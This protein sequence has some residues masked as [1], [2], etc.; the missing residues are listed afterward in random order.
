MSEKGVCKSFAFE[1]VSFFDFGLEIL[2]RLSSIEMN[3]KS[4]QME[5][6]DSRDTEIE[7]FPPLRIRKESNIVI[8]GLEIARGFSLLAELSEGKTLAEILRILNHGLI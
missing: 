5:H 2:K 1:A 3:P 7:K 8:S 6:L 4:I